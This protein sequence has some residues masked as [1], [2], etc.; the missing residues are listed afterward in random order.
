MD[1]N[2]NLRPLAM[3]SQTKRR[4]MG[5]PT[6][7]TCSKREKNLELTQEESAYTKGGSGG[8]SDGLRNEPDYRSAESDTICSCRER[9][10]ERERAEWYTGSGEHG[11]STEKRSGQ[12]NSGSISGSTT[13]SGGVTGRR[14]SSTTGSEKGT[15]DRTDTVLRNGGGRDYSSGGCGYTE[16]NPNGTNKALP[17]GNQS[18]DRRDMGRLLDVV[19][20][21]QSARHRAET[22]AFNTDPKVADYESPEE[23]MKIFMGEFL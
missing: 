8:A 17:G 19:M 13:D 11:K 18:D 6:S 23:I 15:G 16:A 12:R 1:G 4:T 3:E 5:Q 7:Q 21:S 2:P 20:P 10:R 22:V 14:I 9:E